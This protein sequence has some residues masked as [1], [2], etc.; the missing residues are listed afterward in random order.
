MRLHFYFLENKVSIPDLINWDPDSDPSRFS[1]GL[2]HNILEL[3]VRLSKRD[4]IV[5][6]GEIIPSDCDLIVVFKH[7]LEVAT[8][9]LSAFLKLI[10]HPVVHIASDLELNAI[11][12]F[13]PDLTVVPTRKLEN[14]EKSIY[15]P[16]LP[17]RGLIPSDRNPNCLIENVTIKV[18]PEN[19]PDYLIKLRDEN[20][21]RESGLNLIVD[22]PKIT[23]GSDNNWNDFRGIDVTLVL[24]NLEGASDA[25][26]PPTRLFNA[27]LA[28]TIPFVDPID[29]YL[30]NIED[31]KNGFVIYNS[32][33]IL[34]MIKNLNS[35]P[36]KLKVI[37]RNIREAANSIILEKILN[38]YE[39]AFRLAISTTK[40]NRLRIMRMICQLIINSFFHILMKILGKFRFKLRHLFKI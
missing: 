18:N 29:A 9:K 30:E 15:L 16:P 26:K 23:D 12:Q 33:E 28:N 10:K 2:G 14:N 1:S 21:F 22:A 13:S 35:D 17:Q 11:L 3:G 34:P 20:R 27:W 32:N 39:G 25:R 4:Q 36:E 40:I 37:R 19:I 5:S 7:D 31:Q 6:F 38:Q 8:F 24:R